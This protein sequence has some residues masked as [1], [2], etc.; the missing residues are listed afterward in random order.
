MN[1]QNNSFQSF[2]YYNLCQEEIVVKC[3]GAD[4]RGGG[5]NAR[6]PLHVFLGYFG[7]FLANVGPSLRV[8]EGEGGPVHFTSVLVFLIMHM[9]SQ[10]IN[11]GHSTTNQSFISLA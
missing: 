7:N 10:R 5:T 1:Q 6:A 8:L 11:R 3:T 9:F 2:L 4:T